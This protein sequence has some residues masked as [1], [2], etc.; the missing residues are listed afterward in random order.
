MT[1]PLV[2]PI[3]CLIAYH[4][5]YAKNHVSSQW[6]YGENMM[7]VDAYKKV[8]KMIN[9]LECAAAH[10]PTAREGLEAMLTRY[11]ALPGD[12]NLSV[13][14]VRQDLRAVKAGTYDPHRR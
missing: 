8:L 9:D 4:E 11:E 6:I 14:F 3:E 7:V 12:Y 1:H 2:A 10:L 13:E 5:K